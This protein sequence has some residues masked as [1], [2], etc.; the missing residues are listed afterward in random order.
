MLVDWDEKRKQLGMTDSQFRQSLLNQQH[1]IFVYVADEW[2]QG[3]QDEFLPAW[4]A[5]SFPLVTWVDRGSPPHFVDANGR[6]DLSGARLPLV[7]YTVS[8]WVRIPR[9]AV[10]A[11]L[12]HREPLEL[13]G[14]LIGI[15][16]G[17]GELVASLNT[18]GDRRY[19]QSEGFHDWRG[20]FVEVEDLR[21]RS[22]TA[23]SATPEVDP[24]TERSLLRVI[25]ALADMANIPQRGGANAIQL[26]LEQLGFTSPNDDTIR[27]ILKRA[28]A[29][30]ADPKT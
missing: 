25:R 20:T 29:I 11:S 2:C 7:N 14:V 15:E 17:D 3:T 19:I 28:R 9:D 23:C 12:A 26:Q 22:T 21:F 10:A 24:R 8:G 13:R 18:L 1:E 4:D 30:Q 16:G 27:S 5:D 6:R